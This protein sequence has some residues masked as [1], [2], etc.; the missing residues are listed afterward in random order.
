MHNNKSIALHYNKNPDFCYAS[1]SKPY[2]PDIYFEK[3]VTL[4]ETH[5][6]LA[7]HKRAT[8]QKLKK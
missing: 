7:F 4:H 6:S 5:S 8:H 3:L 2:I 1:L